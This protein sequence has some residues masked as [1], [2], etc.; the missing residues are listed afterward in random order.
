MAGIIA[1]SPPI[2]RSSGRRNALVADSDRV[3]S[4]GPEGMGIDFPGLRFII[5]HMIKET[6]CH[7][8]HL[9]AARELLD[10][11]QRIVR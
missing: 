9:D 5:P 7:A 11:R 8:G 4:V 2:K 1:G 10:G 6:A 3:A